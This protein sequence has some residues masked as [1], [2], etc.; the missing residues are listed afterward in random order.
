MGIYDVTSVAAS[1]HCAYKVAILSLRVNGEKGVSWIN[2]LFWV[3]SVISSC[4][5]CFNIESL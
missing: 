4:G 5:C 3:F 2:S 1:G